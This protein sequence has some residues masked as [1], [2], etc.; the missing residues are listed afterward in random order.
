MRYSRLVGP[1]RV[2]GSCTMAVILLQT[3]CLVASQRSARSSFDKVLQTMTREVDVTGDGKKDRI[4]LR[5]MGESWSSPLKWTLTIPS[6]GRT[7]FTYESDDAWLDRFFNDE[8]YV[9]DT[10]GS[11]L[12]CKKLYYLHGILDGLVDKSLVKP[13]W[14]DSYAA[15]CPECV[16]GTPGS[17]YEV[18]TG[19]L[20]TTYKLPPKEADAVVAWIIGELKGGR[21]ILVFVPISAV[22]MD[23]PRIWVPQVGAFLSLSLM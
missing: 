21:A 10:C 8:G 13:G 2:A 4:E 17:I 5:L 6:L 11:Y 22:E 14:F 16:K 19:Q 23:H 3:V 1:A 9:D 7:V 12:A 20:T 15:E 18:L